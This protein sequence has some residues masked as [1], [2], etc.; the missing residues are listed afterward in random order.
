MDAKVKFGEVIRSCDEALSEVV[1]TEDRGK[2]EILEQIRIT[3]RQLARLL[4][5]LMN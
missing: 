5:R 3:Y 4:V 2:R 1:K